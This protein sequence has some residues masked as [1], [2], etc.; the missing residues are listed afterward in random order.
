[1]RYVGSTK[2]RLIRGVVDDNINALQ[3]T[4]T[5]NQPKIATPFKRRTAPWLGASLL[6][7]VLAYFTVPSPMAWRRAP[8]VTKTASALSHQADSAVAITRTE[9][10]DIQSEPR[11]LDREAIPL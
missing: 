7:S 10:Q 9:S 5:V 11:P 4:R 3:G 2:L 6:V 8:V 1:M